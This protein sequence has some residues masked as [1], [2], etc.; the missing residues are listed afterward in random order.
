MT[1]TSHKIS[2]HCF[3]DGFSI[4]QKNQA[5]TFCNN[6]YQTL[7]AIVDR[8]LSKHN[9]L[10][11]LIDCVCFEYPSVFVPKAYFK[12]ELALSFIE[13]YCTPPHS[14]YHSHQVLDL[15]SLVNVFYYTKSIHEI[16]KKKGV[17]LT[18]KHSWNYLLN[19]VFQSRQTFKKD[20]RII[21]FFHKEFFDIFH[22]HRNKFKRTNRFDYENEDELIYYLLCF[23]EANHIKISNIVLIP[24]GKFNQYSMCYKKLSETFKL[25]CFND[26]DNSQQKKDNSHY[27]WKL[28]I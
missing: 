2:I 10:P 6:D 7:P 17:E 19:Y 16:K 14:F 9:P 5:V 12:K 3:L 27:P 24:L 26:L 18:I 22:F 4:Y 21:L 28:F 8:Y 1:T 15:Y 11:L 25:K 13:N 20:Q 23:I